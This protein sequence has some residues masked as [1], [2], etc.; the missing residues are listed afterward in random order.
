MTGR[1]G[2]DAYLH[3]LDEAFRGAG[4]EKSDE[5][6]ALL[7]NLRS[8][9]DVAWRALPPGAARSIQSIAVHVGACKIMYEDYAFGGGTLRFADT[10]LIV[11]DDGEDSEDEAVDHAAEAKMA[12]PEVPTVFAKYANTVMYVNVNTGQRQLLVSRLIIT[13]VAAHWAHRAKNTISP[14]AVGKVNTGR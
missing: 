6:Q 5:S 2:I 1:D 10:G 11:D 4:I 3:L 13:S 14:N 9:P 7:T 12:I 8:V